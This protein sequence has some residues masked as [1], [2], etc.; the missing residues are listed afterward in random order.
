MIWRSLR[1]ISRR[2]TC[3]FILL[4]FPHL[5]HTPPTLFSATTV[6][7]RWIVHAHAALVTDLGI[8]VDISIHDHLGTPVQV[9]SLLINRA[10]GRERRAKGRERRAKGRE[11]SARGGER[12][13]TGG[14]GS[15]TGGER[16]AIG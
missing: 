6:L 10:S 4:F 11:R 12:S 2:K 16:S 5:S 1:Q 8:I 13:V 7:R 9:V 15:V 3:T 14:E